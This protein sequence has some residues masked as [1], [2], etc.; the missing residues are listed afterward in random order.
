MR[1]SWQ[2]MSHD[3]RIR[4]QGIRYVH[5]RGSKKQGGVQQKEGIENGR[6]NARIRCCK[7]TK[8]AHISAMIFMYYISLKKKL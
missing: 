2:G 6:N 4:R 1:V 3:F 7:K 8:R 5:M